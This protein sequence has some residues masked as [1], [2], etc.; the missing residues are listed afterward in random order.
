[1]SRCVCATHGHCFDGLASAALFSELLVSLEPDIEFSYVGCGYGPK[2]RVPPFDGDHNAILD[3]RYHSDPA[4]SFFFDH[5]PTAFVTH[6]DEQHFRQREEELPS[7]FVWDTTS[8]SCAG[9]IARVARD[10]FGVDLE[11]HRQ[12]IEAA[13]MIDGA[14]FESAEEAADRSSPTMR[15]ASVIERIGDSKFLGRAVPIVRKEGLS[16]LA[17]AGF[18]KDAYRHLSPGLSAYEKRVKGRGRMHGRVALIDLTDERVDVISKFAQY[19]FFPQATYSIVVST[20]RTGVKISIGFNPWCGRPLDVDIGSMCARY[21]GGG[22]AVVGA[23]SLADGQQGDA[24][25]LARGL[26][27]SLQQPDSKGTPS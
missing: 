4:L 14:R 20:M 22:H 25:E 19:R 6:E 17:T 12:L 10:Q 7:R 1:M 9:L 18:V 15:V 11:P 3:Y 27:E 8:T 26:A 5:H 16:G 24:L 23:I 13:D 2:E 21:G